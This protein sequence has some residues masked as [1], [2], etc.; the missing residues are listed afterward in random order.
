MKQTP[1]SIQRYGPDTPLH[2]HTV[3]QEYIEQMLERKGYNAFL[4]C[5]VTVEKAEKVNGNSKL[6]L[7]RAGADRDYWWTEEFDAVVVASR[8]YTVLFVPYIEGLEE[9][10]HPHSESAEHSKRYRGA[11]KYREKACCQVILGCQLLYI[12]TFVYQVV[13]VGA[14]V[15][16]MDFA[17]D[18][19]DVAQHPVNAVVRRK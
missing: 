9:F 10:A 19:I 17:R 11:E 12:Q 1:R 6:T 14:S 5:R 3:I 13:V 15:S 18:F 4:E 16:G 7:G 8:Q 2:H